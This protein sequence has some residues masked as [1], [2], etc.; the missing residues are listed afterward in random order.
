MG[1]VKRKTLVINLITGEKVEYESRFAAC[2]SVGME[3][4]RI[5]VYIDK[6]IIFQKKY[7]FLDY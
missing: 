6:G 2:R 4:K 3:R 7:K 5:N 1:I